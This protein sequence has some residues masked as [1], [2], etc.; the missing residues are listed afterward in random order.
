M[1]TWEQVNAATVKPMGNTAAGSCQ[2]TVSRHRPAAQ[3][4]PDGLQRLSGRTLPPGRE[5][6]QSIIMSPGPPAPRT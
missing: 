6:T 1:H 4:D 3:G 5:D 2:A